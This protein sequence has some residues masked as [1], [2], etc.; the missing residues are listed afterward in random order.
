M[1]LVL[2]SKCGCRIGFP[3][4]KS[5]SNSKNWKGFG[6]IPHGLWW[7]ISNKAKTRN[8]I[9]EISIEEAWALF[10]KQGR[11]CAL[12]GIDLVFKS[13]DIKKTASLNRIDSSKGYTLDNIQWVHKRVN[14]MK[15]SLSQEEFIYFCNKI[16]KTQE[17]KN[18]NNV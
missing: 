3:Q 1:T 9:F 10:L 18:E 4:K 13:P 6:E 7:D 8:L 2:Y 17:K 16:S 15:M 14:L 11:K 5:G 12:S